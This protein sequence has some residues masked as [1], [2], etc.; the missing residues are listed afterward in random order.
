[1][2]PAQSSPQPLRK[3]LFCLSPFSA[4]SSA[5]LGA[6]FCSNTSPRKQN[7]KEHLIFQNPAEPSRAIWDYLLQGS[8][9]QLSPS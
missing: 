3:L 1:M 2:F 9:C 7:W 6:N 4:S 8:P 5:H